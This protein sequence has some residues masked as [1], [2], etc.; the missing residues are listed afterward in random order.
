MVALKCV[1]PP[2]SF[3]NLFKVIA[4]SYLC[5]NL[6]TCKVHKKIIDFHYFQS[7][8]SRFPVK[9]FLPLLPYWTCLPLLFCGLSFCR[10]PFV[11]LFVVLLKTSVLAHR[12]PTLLVGVSIHSGSVPE[13]L[14]FSSAVHLLSPSLLLLSSFIKLSSIAGT[15]FFFEKIFTL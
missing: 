7:S 2:P 6:F 4:Y 11:C 8:A 5:L 12:L 10:V 14:L 3:G 1:I 15:A 13:P 9:M